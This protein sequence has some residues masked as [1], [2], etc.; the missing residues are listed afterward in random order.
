MCLR[1]LKAAIQWLSLKL[2]YKMLSG[3]VFVTIFATEQAYRVPTHPLHPGAPPHPILIKLLHD[4]DAILRLLRDHTDLAFDGCK[5]WL[6]PD[7]SSEI[8]KRRA[9]FLDIK[10]TESFKRPILHD[11][12]CTMYSCGT[13]IH[14]SIWFTQRGLNMVGFDIRKW[15]GDATFFGLKGQDRRLL[16]SLI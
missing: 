8:Q 11:V 15:Q 9:Q 5:M 7:F 6:Y 2:G 12:F 10:K 14:I 3:K 16:W 4:R 13:G 1:R